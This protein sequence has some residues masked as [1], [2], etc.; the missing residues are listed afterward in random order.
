MRGAVP[1]CRHA[2]LAALVATAMAAWTPVASG[3]GDLHAQ[4]EQ[5]SAKLR[6]DPGN[7]A[8]LFHRAEL[9]RDHEEWA[10]A[11]ADYD[12]VEA[13]APDQASVH[14]GRGK[15]LLAIGQL[16]ASRRELDRFLDAEP[17][18]AEALATRGAVAMAQARPADG[19]RDF[20]AAIAAS[21]EPDAEMFLALA[22]A[23]MALD[24]PDAPAA[25]ATLDDGMARLGRPVTLGL[26]AVDIAQ[27]SGDVEGALARLD[28]LRAGQARQEAWLERRGNLN[29][30]AGRDADARRDWQAASAALDALAPR[31]A[32]T[33]AMR[34]LRERLDRKLAPRAD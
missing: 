29:A 8:L 14:L 31:L 20:A 26:R 21:P 19:A 10:K 30:V 2:L 27:R 17:A 1:A 25:L 32:N 24:P 23:L 13:L 15:L 33:A 22:D 5:V 16:E 4:I 12:R 7:A 3:H 34:E 11:A 9:Y 6:L 28:A 18:H